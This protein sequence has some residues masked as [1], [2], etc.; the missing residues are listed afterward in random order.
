MALLEGV[1]LVDFKFIMKTHSEIYQGLQ[2]LASWR[3]QAS[4]RTRHSCPPLLSSLKGPEEEE[5]GQSQ[6]AML[7]ART[8][9]NFPSHPEYSSGVGYLIPI[10]I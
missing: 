6:M 9:S 4:W 1:D 3:R 5:S 7:S 10:L 2:S 8:N